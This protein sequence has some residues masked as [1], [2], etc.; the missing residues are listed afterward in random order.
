[1]S[2][3]KL[4]HFWTVS[5]LTGVMGAS[6]NAASE[7]AAAPGDVIPKPYLLH[8][9]GIAGSKYI[10]HSVVRG[11][12]EA[13]FDGDM[14]IYDWTENDPG[15]GALLAYDR[16]H[17]EAKLIAEKLVQHHNAEPGGKIFMLA[18]SG[19]CGLAIWALEDLP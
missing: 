16:N 19:G 13:G 4:R 12:K 15:V 3:I 5:V 1:M 7:I 6:A 17:K 2:W 10:D 8:L 9:P 14:E 18:H 11:I